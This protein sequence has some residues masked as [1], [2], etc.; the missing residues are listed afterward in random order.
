[1]SDT[2]SSLLDRIDD[3]ITTSPHMFG[4]RVRL[5]ADAGI[6][7]LLGTVNSFYHKQMAQETVR[8]VDGVQSIDNRL[9]VQWN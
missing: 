2:A 3:A 5:E 4:H 6:V 1:M 7:V 9:E 8:R